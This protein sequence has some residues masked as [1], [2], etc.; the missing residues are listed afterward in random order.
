MLKIY[1]LLCITLKIAEGELKYQANDENEKNNFIRTICDVIHAHKDFETFFH[2]DNG[3]T[4]LVDKIIMDINSKTMKS[5]NL[6][7]YDE[8]VINSNDLFIRPLVRK[9]L[10]VII[11]SD[12][13]SFGL[14]LNVSENV[15]EHDEA[16]FIIPNIDIDKT[17]LSADWH[18]KIFGKILVI[19]VDVKQQV[20]VNAICYFCGKNSGKIVPISANGA[21]VSKLTFDKKEFKDFFQHTFKVGFTEYYPFISCKQIEETSVDN[22]TIHICLKATGSE[23]ELIA[24]MSQR[25]NFTYELILYP[26]YTQLISDLDTGKIDFVIGGITATSERAERTTFTRQYWFEGYYFLYILS[27]NLKQ[28]LSR[29]LDPFDGHLWLLF[30]TSI[31]VTAVVLYALDR[32]ESSDIRK[33]TCSESLWVSYSFKKMFALLNT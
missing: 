28:E 10:N 14:F 26:T 33:I 25:L 17:F 18:I 3:Y 30:A 15:N 20:S 6:I 11:L 9:I 27:S 16:L 12:M 29:V 32:V 4:T 2:F 24:M 22:A 8:N 13:E 5:V 31:F 1:V 23:S 19:M 21:F 7:Y